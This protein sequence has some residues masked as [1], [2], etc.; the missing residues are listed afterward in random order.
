MKATLNRKGILEISAETGAEAYALKK[1]A[2][3]NTPLEDLNEAE[4]VLLS[5]VIKMKL[6]I[7]F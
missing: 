5:E 3:E 6:L 7:T 1:W 4:A 2:E